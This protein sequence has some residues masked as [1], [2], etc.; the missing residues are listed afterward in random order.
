MFMKKSVSLL[1]VLLLAIPAISAVEI[2]SSKDVYYPQETIQAE[3]TGNFIDALTKDNLLIY[4]QGVPRPYPVISDLTKQGNI[5]Y[6]YAILPNQEGN[7]SL[8]IENIRYTESGVEETSAIAKEFEIKKTNESALQINPG[9]IKASIDFS[10]KVKSLY[11]NQE[12]SATFKQQT[13][14]LSLIEDSEKT[15]Q[16][17]I[18]NISAGKYNLSINSYIIPVFVT[19][20][21]VINNTIINQTNQ[22]DINQTNQTANETKINIENKTEDEIKAMHCSDFGKKC[23]DNEECEVETKPSIEGSC[24]PGACTEKKEKSYV[25]LGILIIVI[26]LVA[27]VFL[28]LNAKKKK[29]PTSDEI[30]KTKYNKFNERMSGENREVTGKLDTV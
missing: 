10:V 25:W 5:Y 6:F 19:E 4:K 12:I 22:A 27:V 2:K 18:M 24:C 15:I 20:E 8:K 11:K 13:Q 9:F 16:F 7:F 14:N 21:A 28:Y 3:I 23:E 17:S 26:V 1:F 29:P 30:L